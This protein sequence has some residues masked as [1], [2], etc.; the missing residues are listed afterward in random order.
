MVPLVI[1]LVAGGL[2]FYRLGYPDRIYFDETYYAPQGQQYLANGVEEDFAVHPPVGKWFIAVGIGV[3]GYDSFGY[4][5]AA[6]AAGTV[7]VL[8]TYLI[9]LRL[10]RRR[11]VAALAAFLLAID[12]LAFTMSRI[13]MLDAFLAMF[14]ALG[15]L[16][17]VVDRDEQWGALRGW[18]PPD[19]AD[20]D[21]LPKRSRW[22]RWA[23]GVAFGLA[24]STKW[25]AVLPIAGAGLFVLVSEL[26]WRRRATGRAL[27]RWWQIVASGLLTLV[28]VPLVVYVASYAG[29]FANYESNRLGR[30]ECPNGVCEKSVPDLVRSWW[31]EQGQIANFHRNLQAEHPYR[32]HPSTWPLL[33]RPVAYYYESCTDEKLADDECVTE[34]GNVEEILGIGNPLVWWLALPAYAGAL[35]LVVRRRNWAAATSLGFVLV[36]YVPWLFVSRPNFLFYLTP[37]VPFMCLTLAGVVAWVGAKRGARWVPAAVAVAAAVAFVFWYP[38]FVGEETSTGA[39]KLRIFFT[40]WI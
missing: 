35:W 39:W 23:A 10:F 29:W 25:S 33:L 34:Q 15:V 21:H 26:L 12:G 6:A 27:T 17:L 36:Q 8:L 16:L 3:F 30:T 22:A 11:G 18:H 20:P 28:V 14:V 37:A 32:S 5:S 1:V 38:L 13:A 19:D 9:G 31:G 4:R 24:L 2:R 7:T 40:S